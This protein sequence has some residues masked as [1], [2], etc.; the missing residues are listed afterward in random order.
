MQLPQDSEIEISAH[1]LS[2]RFPIKDAVGT[3]RAGVVAEIVR[4]ELEQADISFKKR[5][6]LGCGHVAAMDK[7]ILPQGGKESLVEPILRS[8]GCEPLSH[9]VCGPRL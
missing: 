8:P 4:L 5:F 6:L 2:N 3:E 9:P 7:G 1:G